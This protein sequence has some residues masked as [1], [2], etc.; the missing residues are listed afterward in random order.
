MVLA[1]IVFL[2]FAVHV[3]F[4]DVPLA[5]T[6]FMVVGY[7]FGASFVALFAQL[8]GGIYTKAA[9]VGADMVGK[10]STG[11]AAVTR[12]PRCFFMEAP[13]RWRRT[14]PRTTRATLQSLLIWWAIM[15]AIAP[16]ARRIFLRALPRRLLPP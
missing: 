10:V 1:G 4:P 6:P 14:F 12:S 3:V 8:G 7:G 9:D 5:Q 2:F 11:C 13:R 16:V 15:S